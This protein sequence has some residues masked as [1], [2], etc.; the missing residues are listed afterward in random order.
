MQIL[1]HFR[2]FTSPN[3]EVE[4]YARKKLLKLSHFNNKIMEV[5]VDI[6]AGK[7]HTSPTKYLTS[8]TLHLPPKH[9]LHAE[10][11]GQTPEAAIDKVHDELVRE[12]EKHND[13][14]DKH[15][16]HKE[17]AE[18]EAINQFPPEEANKG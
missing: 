18:R 9:I 2:H 13:K 16:T 1:I 15:L 4:D 3:Q 14:D 17:R 10:S 8:V 7:E 11:R 6:D 12:I 5:H